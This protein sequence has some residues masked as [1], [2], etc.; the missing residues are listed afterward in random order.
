[1]HNRASFGWIAIV[2]RRASGGATGNEPFGNRTD[3]CS[4]SR[5]N[6]IVSMADWSAATRS[7]PA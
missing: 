6:R 3:T 1:M 5:K 7:A 4:V 2:V